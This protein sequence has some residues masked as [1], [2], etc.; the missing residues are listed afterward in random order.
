MESSS[1][2][3]KTLIP[4]QRW[5]SI[6]YRPLSGMCRAVFSFLG[7]KPEGKMY[8]ELELEE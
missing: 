4:L 8:E 1:C 2:I 6:G 7:V 3:L 5:K